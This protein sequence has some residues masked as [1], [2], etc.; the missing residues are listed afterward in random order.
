MSGPVWQAEAC[1]AALTRLPGIG[2]A[3]LV[4]ILSE[5]DPRE[6][7]QSVLAG[8]LTRPAPTPRRLPAP[9]PLAGLA[10]P[11]DHRIT[12]AEAAARLD[13]QA[14]WARASSAGIGVTWIGRQ[15]F[16][17]SLATDPHPPGVLFFRGSLEWLDRP[18]VAIVG[19]RNAT[20]AGRAVAYEM[21]RDLAAAGVC[22][23][24]GLALGIDGSAH[25]GALSAVDQSRIPSPAAPE[26]HNADAAATPTVGVAASGV[27]V[28][29]PKRH[30]E[31]WKRVAATGAVVS[32]TPPGYQAE[33]WR[34]PSRNRII[35]GLVRIVV[36][37]ESHAAGGSLITA[38]AAIERGLEVRVVPGPVDSPASAGSNQ[39]LYDGAGPVRGATDVLDAL[40][41][42]L[43]AGPRAA[44]THGADGAD[45]AAELGSPE[46][47]VLSA[48]GWT[49]V[50]VNR[51]A[52]RCALELPRVA[53]ALE[54][55]AARGLVADERGWW[56]RIRAGERSRPCPP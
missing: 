22:V 46:A 6:A 11:G 12:W 41:M 37:V 48:V 56:T 53:I 49:P 31:L 34:F 15:D 35:A 3:R 10:A 9:L 19:T 20:P 25:R 28:P 32:E 40:G 1:A 5:H 54:Q 23:V 26:S 38:E 16:P 52:G 51:I 55:L 47:A 33:A 30:A 43:P 4:E 27:D 39:L 14:S 29:Y 45:G 50:S 36:V 42:L 7:W 21:G 13:V 17:R 2:P 8:G 18:C 44:H 24:S